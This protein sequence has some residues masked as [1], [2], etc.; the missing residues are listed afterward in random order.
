MAGLEVKLHSTATRL[1]ESG[2]RW[3]DYDPVQ[4]MQLAETSIDADTEL[5]R[6]R[7]GTL[8]AA[9]LHRTTRQVEVEVEVEVAAREPASHCLFRSRSTS[10]QL[11]PPSDHFCLLQSTNTEHLETH[12]D[13]DTARYVCP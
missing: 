2:T 3:L 7:K 11:R 6:L 4:T 5:T 8:R 10:C 9:L 13:T 12:T 1:S